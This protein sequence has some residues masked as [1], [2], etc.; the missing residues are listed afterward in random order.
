MAKET[1]DF[2][3]QVEAYL[4][5]HLSSEQVD[6]ALEQQRQ[7][8]SAEDVADWINRR[9]IAASRINDPSVPLE[10]PPPRPEDRE[11][12]ELGDGDR[13]QVEALVH[14]KHKR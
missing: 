14:R 13:V 10:G 8:R 3:I 6:E 2:V 11:S 12:V 5:W 7:G 9:E 1:Q 4:G